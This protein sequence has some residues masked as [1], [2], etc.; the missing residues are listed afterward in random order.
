M[1]VWKA[2][3]KDE[4]PKDAKVITTTWAMKKKN[5]FLLMWLKS[6][7]SG[8]VQPPGMG[9]FLDQQRGIDKS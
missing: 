3:P 2:V 5:M 7:P 6:N 4:V 1:N 8:Y 9:E